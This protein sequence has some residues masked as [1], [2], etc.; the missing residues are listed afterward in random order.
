MRIV[1]V[2]GLPGTGKS[3]M[4]GG[5]AGALDAVVLRSDEVR[6]E[7]AGLPADRP[8]PAPFGEGLYRAEATAATYAEML[9]RAGAALSHGESVV[10]DASWTAETQRA[11]ARE[12]AAA[13]AADLVEIRCRAEPDTAARRLRRRLAAGGDPSDA[14]PEIAAQLAVAADPWPAAAAIDTGRGPAEALAEAMAVIGPARAPRPG[15]RG[16]R[17]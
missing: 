1:L 12:L 2:G 6:K 4:A 14:T 11:R 15:V 16:G 10:M 13:H 7:L 9:A 5:L 17:R 3:T 8:S